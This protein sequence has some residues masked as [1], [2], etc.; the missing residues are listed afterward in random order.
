MAQITVAQQKQI[1]N[2]AEQVWQQIAM[3]IPE[4]SV[5]AYEMLETSIDA[6]RL[7]TFGHAEEHNLLQQMITEPGSYK[8]MMEKLLTHAPYN[9]YEAGGACEQY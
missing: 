9:S 6:N 8:V 4:N 3:D 7:E 2:A 1:F 5:S